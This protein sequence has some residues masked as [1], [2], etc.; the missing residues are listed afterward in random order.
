MADVENTAIVPPTA[1]ITET[2]HGSLSALSPD[3]YDQFFEDI[4]EQLFAASPAASPDE[5]DLYFEDVPQEFLHP[6]LADPHT[7]QPRTSDGSQSAHMDPSPAP[8]R[9]S[10]RAIQR[11]APRPT[12]RSTSA[13][14]KRLPGQSEPDEFDLL[15]EASEF[16]LDEKD[17]ARLEALEEHERLTSPHLP[18]EQQDV[19]A[20]RRVDALRGADIR[21][22][23]TKRWQVSADHVTGRVKQRDE[24]TNSV[25]PVHEQHDAAALKTWVY[26]LNVPKRQYQFD[27]SRQCL[28]ENTFVA[29]PTGLGKTFIAGVVMLNF[30]RWFPLGKIIFCA[31]TKPLVD[32]QL[33]ACHQA[34]GIP[35]ADAIKLDGE[36]KPS[37]RKQAWSALR[38]FYVT[39]Q[40]LMNDLKEERCDPRH[41]VLIV[42]DEAHRGTGSYAYATVMQYMMSTN[43]FFRVLAMSATPGGN[44]QAVQNVVDALHIGQIAI[45]HEDEPDVRPYIET[46]DVKV[47]IV[48]LNPHGCRLRDLL[49]EVMQPT[50]DAV[51]R[52]GLCVG[53]NDPVKFDAFRAR[54]ATMAINEDRK[55]ELFKLYATLSQLGSLAQAMGY[56]LEGTT[57]MAHD[58]ILSATL[59]TNKSGK[60]SAFSQSPGAIQLTR[61]VLHQ[62]EQGSVIHPK[63]IAT[64]QILLEH[65]SQHAEENR[66]Q[67]TDSG[68]NRTSAIVFTNNRAAV[69][70]I[71]DFISQESPLIR[72]A[73]FVGQGT[74]KNGRKG[75]AQHQQIDIIKRFKAGELNVL[76]STS[77][78]EEGLDV[79]EVDVVVCYESPKTPVRALQRVGRTGR[80]RHGHVHVLLAEVREERNWELAMQRYTQ[81]Q[82]IVAD[83]RALKFYHDGHY[84]LPEG[85]EPACIERIMDVQ[86][87]N[88]KLSFSNRIALRPPP[89][90]DLQPETLPAY[91][92]SKSRS[93]S[94]ARAT[95]SAAYPSIDIR[96]ITSTQFQ[97]FGVD[98]DVDRAIEVGLGKPCAP[99]ALRPSSSLHQP[100][101]EPAT[102]PAYLPGVTRAT[103]YGSVGEAKDDAWMYTPSR[104]GGRPEREPTPALSSPPSS[105][106]LDPPRGRKRARPARVDSS[107]S[108]S[109]RSPPL[110]RVHKDKPSPAERVTSISSPPHDHSRV[111]RRERVHPRRHNPHVDVEAVHSGSEESAGE[112]E[113]RDQPQHIEGDGDEDEDGLIAQFESSQVSESYDQRAVYRQSLLS[114]TSAFKGPLFQKPPGPAQVGIRHRRRTSSDED[115]SPPSANEY[116]IDSFVVDDEE[117][118]EEDDEGEDGDAGQEGV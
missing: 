91:V 15:L 101:S 23:R 74:D 28:F 71:V 105:A 43:P 92:A 114:Q 116:E 30:Y 5:Y 51:Q 83:G 49:A 79:G 3:Q 89:R 44:V 67:N 77:I 13:S 63:M 26:P 32:Q 62:Q 65:F 53:S 1:I 112:D 42:F 97:A 115:L 31:P 36:V 113:D 22:F 24:H 10:P 93:P 59:K 98:D 82:Q 56:L 47:H 80:R 64:K 87:Y 55:T 111:S 88:P 117:D 68:Q 29:L 27:I 8:L 90:V 95:T 69:L 12:S 78:G 108:A 60:P 20:F 46:K 72:P 35:A 103:T 107:P 48:P 70:E 38:V 14:P 21:N 45:R 109:D 106:H 96:N 61:E 102:L 17:L 76:V 40:T 11:A 9:P 57:R 4:P 25:R 73:A 34:C 54:S 6:A 100:L 81:L 104:A 86:E 18:A 75:L 85:H 19:P 58:T 39:P 16:E 2:L 110:R 84:L 94:L 99:P 66:A 7:Q 50:I 41:V 52:S 118:D 37:Q 33:H